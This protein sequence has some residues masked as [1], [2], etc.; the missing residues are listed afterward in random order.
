MVKEAIDRK[1]AIA[2]GNLRRARA[3]LPKKRDAA[4]DDVLRPL[5][6]RIRAESC[7]GG[8]DHLGLHPRDE[9]RRPREV[10]RVLPFN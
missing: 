8:D 3:V 10:F 7:A 5:V 9:I 2:D 1:R 6:Q 4:R